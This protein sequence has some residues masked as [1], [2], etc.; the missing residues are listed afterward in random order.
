MNALQAV[1]TFRLEMVLTS[2]RAV[3]GRDSPPQ[4]DCHA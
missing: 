3:A 1:R 4:G 2:F